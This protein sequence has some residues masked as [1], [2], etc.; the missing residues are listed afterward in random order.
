M[1]RGEKR[2]REEGGEEE[3]EREETETERDRERGGGGGVHIPW[4]MTSVIRC[5][6]LSDMLIDRSIHMSDN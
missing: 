2:R 1:E 4:T 3:R 5:S 6:Y